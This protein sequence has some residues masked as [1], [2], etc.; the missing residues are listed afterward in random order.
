MAVVCCPPHLQCLNL[1]WLSV[2]RLDVWR[3]FLWLHP[4]DVLFLMALGLTCSLAG[5][6]IN[7]LKE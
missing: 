4:D 5:V 2:S 7:Q 6:V 3:K 1:L